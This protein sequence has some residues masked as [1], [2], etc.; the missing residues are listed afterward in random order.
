MAKIKRKNIDKHWLMFMVRGVLAAVFG[1]LVLFS[2]MKE[3]G[4]I[5]AMMSVFLLLMGII[6]AVGALYSSTQK[7]DWVNSI[8][9]ALVDVV[10]AVTLLFYAKDSLVSS[11]I[12]ISVYTIVSGVID[13]LH[14]F[15]ATNDATDKFIRILAGMFGCV[16][17]LVILN[18][19]NFEVMM[20]VR[21][22]GAYMLIVG[23]TSMIYG[24]HNREQKIEDKIAR[25][26]SRKKSKK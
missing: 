21:F 24:I 22:F 15:L 18:A 2:G 10:A 23:A 9:D 12:V 7:H 14:G 13:I 5:I 8:V 16:M 11:L 19:G 25:S 20:F 3:I 6:D 1:C 17:G 26:E 4:D